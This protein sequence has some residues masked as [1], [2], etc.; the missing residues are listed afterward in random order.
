[1]S[2]VG[3]RRLPLWVDDASSEVQTVLAVAKIEATGND[4]VVVDDPLLAIGTR[5]SEPSLPVRQRMALCDRHTGVGADGVLTILPARP[6]AAAVG[7]RYRMHITNPDG[8]VP[9]MCGN[10]LRCVVLHLARTGRFP[11]SVDPQG[12]SSGPDAAPVDVPIDTDAGVRIC[13]I[14]AALT[15]VTIDMGLAAFATRQFTPAWARTPLAVDDT[16]PSGDVWID[17]LLATTVSM[18]NPHLVLEAPSLPGVDE[19]TRAGRTLEFLR[20]RFP[21]RTN[22]EWIV[23][24]AGAPNA[25]GSNDGNA[26]VDVVVWERGAG[27]TQACGTGACAVAAALIRAGRRSLGRVICHLPGGPLTIDVRDL[28]APILMTGP[29]RQAFSAVVTL[30][31]TSSLA[32]LVP[33]GV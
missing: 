7:A 8:S 14:N 16:T 5:G 32:H 21:E 29:V 17:G 11:I 18:G 4:F 25:H 31:S 27:L 10:G 24:R 9:E 19:A 1:M 33:A 13:R 23:D 28:K 22:I 15:D 6:E 12:K 2:D 30:P 20:T 3:A 26:D